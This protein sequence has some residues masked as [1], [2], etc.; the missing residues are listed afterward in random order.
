MYT[1]RDDPNYPGA[2]P[3]ISIAARSTVRSSVDYDTFVN[4]Y[5]RKISR[6]TGMVFAG[7][8][9]IMAV[10]MTVDADWSVV[11][12]AAGMG[13]VGAG[14]AGLL[15]SW[16]SHE[17]WQ[18]N[19]YGVSMTETYA[20][21]PAPAASVRP[22]VASTNGKAITT[23]R[24][25]LSPAV[26]QSL[27]NSALSNGGQVTRDGVQ[28]SGIERRWYHTDPNAPDGYRALLA[29]LRQLQFVD[30]RNRLTDIAL[31]WYGEQFPALP[32]A[33]LSRSV[34]GRSD[35]ARPAEDTAAGVGGV[36]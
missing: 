11:L 14:G 23:G 20:P 31:A 27:F 5:A 18:N 33:A 19:G 6:Y 12:L 35:Y 2:L 29:E 24:L 10:I 21:P 3:E 25:V 22:F 1:L 15:A 9:G 32:L 26:W 16:H 28:A 8:A 7:V 30:H 13:L 34:A 36:E 17:Q 4:G